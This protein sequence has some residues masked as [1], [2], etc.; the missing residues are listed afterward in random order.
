MPL[1]V[2]ST[3]TRAEKHA[4]IVGPPSAA[5]KAKVFTTTAL[6]IRSTKARTA[7]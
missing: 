2:F 4:R 1:A 6:N 3:E 5:P 7:L